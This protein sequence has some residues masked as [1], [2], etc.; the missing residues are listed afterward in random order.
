MDSYLIKTHEEFNKILSER[1]ETGLD[2]IRTSINNDII[3]NTVSENFELWDDYNSEFLKSSFNNSDNEYR[4]AY[5]NAAMF[6]GLYSREG[7]DT[8]L[9]KK[10]REKVKSLQKLHG[11]I[12]LIKTRVAL[13]P[14]LE[15]IAEK[16]VKLSSE[17]FIVHG[18]NDTVKLDVARTIEQLGFSPIILNEKANEGKTVI[19]KFETHADVSFAIILMTKDDVGNVKTESNMNPRARQNVIFEFGFFCGKHGR[20]RVCV[21]HEKGVELP[22]DIHGFVYVP[23]DSAGAWKLKVVNEMKAVGYNVD[24]NLLK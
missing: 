22:S 6:S 12:D 14:I 5:D 7:K 13:T 10:I 3:Y 21:L 8:I 24:A 17:I 1:I 9:K 11:K 19:E 18:H 4:L 16:K 20:E 2:F 15:D 23:I